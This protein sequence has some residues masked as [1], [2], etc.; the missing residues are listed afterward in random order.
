ML[1]RQLA[2]FGGRIERGVRARGAAPG[3]R[4]RHGDAGATPTAS[5]RR[6]SFRYVVGCDGAHSAVRRLLGIA[7]EGDA[8]PMGFMLGDVR[9]AWPA[10]QELP[11]GMALRVLRPKPDDAPDMLIAIPLPEP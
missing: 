8:F 3:C 1:T 2:R 5:A 7:F 9:I 10:G 4:Q 6:A 11:R